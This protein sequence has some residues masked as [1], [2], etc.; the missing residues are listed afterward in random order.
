MKTF[1]IWSPLVAVAFG[2]FA[3]SV[4][5]AEIGSNLGWEVGG[6]NG[7]ALST[8]KL[9]EPLA[10]RPRDRDMLKPPILPR[11]PPK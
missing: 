5:A 8:T 10:S 7:S 6:G 1:K 9:V 11:I 2:A 4:S 3:L